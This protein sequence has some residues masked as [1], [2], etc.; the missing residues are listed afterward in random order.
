[1]NVQ[2]YPT[3]DTEQAQLFKCYT[4]PQNILTPL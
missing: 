1:M 2:C 3:S 4:L